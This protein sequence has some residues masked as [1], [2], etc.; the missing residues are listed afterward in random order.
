MENLEIH[1]EG[2]NLGGSVHVAALVLWPGRLCT[3]PD[4]S[5]GD[6]TCGKKGMTVL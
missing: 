2:E 3:K 4:H 6:Q 5:A 1:S